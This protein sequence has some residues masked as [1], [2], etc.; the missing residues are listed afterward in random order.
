MIITKC[1]LK[2]K[3]LFIEHLICFEIYIL[4]SISY[5]L[6][7]LADLANKIGCLLSLN[8]R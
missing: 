2:S 5:R 3:Q 8:F 6:F 4:I 7:G 1:I